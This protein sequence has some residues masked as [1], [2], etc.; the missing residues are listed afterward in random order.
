MENVGV[1]CWCNLQGLAVDWRRSFC[2]VFYIPAV[3]TLGPKG[4]Y[5]RLRE[6][7]LDVCFISVFRRCT[8]FFV[9]SPLCIVR[10]F[11]FLLLVHSPLCSDAKPLTVLLSKKREETFRTFLFFLK[12]F[13]FRVIAKFFALPPTLF[14][15]QKEKRRWNIKIRFYHLVL[16]PLCLVSVVYQVILYSGKGKKCVKFM[17]RTFLSCVAVYYLF[18]VLRHCTS[19]GRHKN[20]NVRNRPK[21]RFSWYDS[22]WSEGVEGK[23]NITH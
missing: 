6:G 21:R 9:F 5:S 20:Y 18:L 8:W 22:T 23:E 15:V 3:W 4:L 7:L 17:T 19:H 16:F 12:M 2:V 14:R 11:C 13:F 1:G 10:L